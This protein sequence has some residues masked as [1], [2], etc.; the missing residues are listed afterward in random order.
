MTQ[1][2]ALDYGLSEPFPSCL[3]NKKGLHN[4]ASVNPFYTAKLIK[5]RAKVIFKNASKKVIQEHYSQEAQTSGNRK[6]H[7]SSF[8]ILC[9]HIYV[10]NQ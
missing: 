6:D 1:Q 5:Q 7:Q 8:K 3:V 4:D 9:Y 10:Y 2:L